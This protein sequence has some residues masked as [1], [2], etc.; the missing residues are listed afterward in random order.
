MRAYET[1]ADLRAEINEWKAA[2]RAVMQGQEYV[3][4]TRRLRRADLSEIN[5]TI[6]ELCAEVTDEDDRAGTGFPRFDQ[7][8]PGRYS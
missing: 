8:I 5:K 7:A 6:R 2:R 1:R 3:I 4:G